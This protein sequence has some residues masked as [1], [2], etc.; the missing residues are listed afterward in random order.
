MF[1]T[2]NVF[3]FAPHALAS[4]LVL[5]QPAS[6]C[7]YLVNQQRLR[8]F[9][10]ATK[11]LRASSTCTQ[12]MK[13]VLNI[14]V[15]QSVAVNPC[16]VRENIPSNICWMNK[17]N[18]CGSLGQKEHMRIYYACRKE[19][20]AELRA[21]SLTNPELIQLENALECKNNR[22]SFSNRLWGM[23]II[24][25]CASDR[26]QQLAGYIVTFAKEQHNPTHAQTLLVA[27]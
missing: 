6:I 3:I 8:A 20:S 14:T 15:Y 12:I 5:S 13:T 1:I 2:K 25:L 17:R 23:W 19:G 7:G 21:E 4:K 16:S 26:L 24:S 18:A 11:G 27:T 10:R 22:L 9:C